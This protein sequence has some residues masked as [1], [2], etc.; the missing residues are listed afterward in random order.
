VLRGLARRILSLTDEIKT[1]NKQLTSAL[2]R[3]AP[4][5]LE[6]YGVGP[7]SAAVLLV[8]AGDNPDRLTSES[9]FA[10]LCGVSPIEMSSGKTT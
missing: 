4:K 9:A 7:D 8:T 1:L 10:A 5:L 3:C 2:S 6:R